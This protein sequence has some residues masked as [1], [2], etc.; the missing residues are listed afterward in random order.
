MNL[1]SERR[2]ITFRGE[3][4]DYMYIGWQCPKTKEVFATA[5]V[6]DLALTQ[7]YMQYRIKH[8][9]PFPTDLLHMRR[10]LGLSYSEMAVLL[11]MDESTYKDYEEGIMPKEEDT[12]TLR[13]A[14]DFLQL[15]EM[16]SKCGLPSKRKENV[17]E[18]IREV[19]EHALNNA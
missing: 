15:S 5:E 13:H 2:K 4:F 11:M 3:E 16:V 6:E 12:E 8:D 1:F 10:I 17:R 19:L 9:I 18:K 14:T 7:I